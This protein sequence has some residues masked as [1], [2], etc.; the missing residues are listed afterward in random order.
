MLAGP[1]YDR[2]VATGRDPATAP[3]LGE[4]EATS[5]GRLEIVTLDVT[6]EDSVRAAATKVARVTDKLALL[7]N[8]AGILHGDNFGPERRLADVEPEQLQR[9]FAVN[10]FGPL[11][12][13][14]HFAPLF[15][16][17]E[18][19][20]LANLSARVGSIDDNALGG[21]YG[22]RASKAAQNMFTR[23]LSIE[24]KRR[25]HGIICVALHPGTVDT[26][27]S[28]PFQRGVA[29]Q[30]LFPPDRA[31]A[32]LLDVIAHLEADDNGGFYA[33]D[34]AKIAW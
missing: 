9:V 26:A 32:Q 1:D 2:V 22:Y 6:V 7:I 4:L 24:L 16:R 33:W 17:R 20:V 23:N 29:P 31:A 21:W 13:A 12:V 15:D 30:K 5:A 18:R 27:L 10:A 11:L 25:H 14:K 28:Q 8:C 34:G 3:A 19:T